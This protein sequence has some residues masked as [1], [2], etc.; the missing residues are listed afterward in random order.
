MYHFLDLLNALDIAAKSSLP[1]FAPLLNLIWLDLF[2]M[3]RCQELSLRRV[4]LAVCLT[5]LTVSVTT[6][7]ARSALPS[8]ARSSSRDPSILT[9]GI[10]F[11]YQKQLIVLQL[12]SSLWYLV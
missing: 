7:V 4:F 11:S 5:S 8:N 12:P 10:T 9:K 2:L 6:A 3:Y 1:F